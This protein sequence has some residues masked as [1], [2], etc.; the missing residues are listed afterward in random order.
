MLSSIYMSTEQTDSKLLRLRS[1][2]VVYVDWA[3]VYGWNKSLKRKISL[4][5]LY[6][7]FNAYEN[8]KDIRFYFGEDV[9]EKSKTFLS[10]VKTIGYTLVSKAV[11]YIASGKIYGQDIL[12][13]KFHFYI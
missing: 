5:K 9:N 3:N 7:Y 8:V 10:E 12:L 11:K 1:K 2:A 4:V 6:G 13:K